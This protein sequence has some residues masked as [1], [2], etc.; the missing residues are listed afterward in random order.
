MATARRLCCRC[1]LTIV[2]NSCA[3]ALALLLLVMFRP[4]FSPA[5]FALEREKELRLVA[6][7]ELHSELVERPSC[8]CPRRLSDST[9]IP[10]TMCANLSLPL[11][12]VGLAEQ[13]LG[14]HHALVCQQ[15]ILTRRFCA[16][17]P[18]NLSSPPSQLPAPLRHVIWNPAHR[19]LAD[20]HDLTVVLLAGDI[21]ASFPANSSNWLV[22]HRPPA[23]V[24]NQLWRNNFAGGGVK[25]NRVWLPIG[26]LWI[27]STKPRSPWN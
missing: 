24:P 11:L 20:L 18:N 15:H 13:I 3:V 4:C 9:T 2:A 10:A 7:S 5:R 27:R 21:L 17:K 12:V 26:A 22:A 1:W 23:W 6:K 8:A 16:P 25:R 19:D 14:P